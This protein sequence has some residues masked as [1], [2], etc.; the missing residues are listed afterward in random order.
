MG[1]GYSETW[2]NTFGPKEF[3]IGSS[4]HVSVETA[5]IIVHEADEQMCSLTCLMPTR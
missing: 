1:Y 2:V 4:L 3:S 5:Q